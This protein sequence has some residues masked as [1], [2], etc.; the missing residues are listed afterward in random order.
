MRTKVSVGQYVDVTDSY[1]IYGSY[2][3][4]FKDRFL[5][6]VAER[7]FHSA[8]PGKSRTIRS[9]DPRVQREIQAANAELAAERH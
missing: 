4:D 1:H 7:E 9:D 8:S 2:F 5:K 6:A 3:P